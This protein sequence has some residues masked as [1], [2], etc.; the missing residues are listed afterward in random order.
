MQDVSNIH[1]GRAAIVCGSAPSLFEDYEKAIQARP[2]AVNIGINE[3]ASGVFCD[4]IVT[5]HPEQAMKFKGISKNKDV[6]VISPPNKTAKTGVDV[7]LVG[8][9]T[10]GSSASAAI[11]AANIMGFDE[12]ILCG[13]PM[14]G[15]DGYFNDGRTAQ[16]NPCQ[17]RF[18]YNI[19]KSSL[20]SHQNGFLK[21][22]RDVTASVYSMSGW[23]KEQ[24]GSL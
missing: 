20:K 16:G 5:L 23:T 17:P 18:G 7:E 13:C 11:L 8:I 19:K 3:A 9:R 22:V 15:G 24:I 14:N 12:V 2:E 1:K 10:Q 6:V 21:A 4:Y